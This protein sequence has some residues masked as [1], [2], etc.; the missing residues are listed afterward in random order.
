[1]NQ[2]EIYDEAL[3]ALLAIASTKISNDPKEIKEDIDGIVEEAKRVLKLAG[4]DY[5]MLMT[6]D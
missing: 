1:M 5:N 3:K 4:Y 6:K 2:L